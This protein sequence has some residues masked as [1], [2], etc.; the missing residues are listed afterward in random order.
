M[1]AT[2]GLYGALRK[3]VNS[4]PPSEKLLEL[5]REKAKSVMFLMPA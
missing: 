3:E 5:E 4:Q 2:A 1:V